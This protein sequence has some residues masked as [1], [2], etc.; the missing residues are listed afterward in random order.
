MSYR[1][2]VIGTIGSG[3]DFKIADEETLER[4]AE[5]GEDHR[6]I[7]DGPVTVILVP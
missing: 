6:D 2:T 3:R 7:I 4:I 5:L 1:H